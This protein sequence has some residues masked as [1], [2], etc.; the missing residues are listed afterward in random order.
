MPLTEQ[1]L[2][3]F[4]IGS[5][6]VIPRSMAIAAIFLAVGF[7]LSMFCAIRTNSKKSKYQQL[8]TASFANRNGIP[9][10]TSYQDASAAVQYALP[11]NVK[12]DITYCVIDGRLVDDR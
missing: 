4:F 1:L 10:I 11:S 7:L 8:G 2:I 3:A 6:M 9:P 12:S 5:N